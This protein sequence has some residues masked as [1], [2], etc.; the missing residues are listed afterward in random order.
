[1][2]TDSKCKLT[3]RDKLH[4]SLFK[5]HVIHHFKSLKGFQ[6]LCYLI[7]T[8]PSFCLLSH[9]LSFRLF[10]FVC[11]LILAQLIHIY[12]TILPKVQI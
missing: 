6:S 12:L 4:P 2:C 9:H 8:L 11:A 5:S 3:P 7:H 1:M 10:P